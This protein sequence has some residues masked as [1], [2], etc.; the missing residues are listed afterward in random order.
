MHAGRLPVV[1]GV[2]GSRSS[3]SALRWGARQSQ[4]T[5]CPLRG[6]TAWHWPAAYGRVLSTIAFDLRADTT[7]LLSA[8][9]EQL[10]AEF[11]ELVLEQLVA[12]G[13]P[14]EVL[15]E[16]SRDASLLVVGDRGRS[17]VLDMVLGSVAAHCIRQAACPVAVMR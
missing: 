5:G 12:E 16:Q 13:H 10:L 6:V 8:V 17:A 3:L 15:V 4:L 14:A 11:P 2:D 9:A 1:V 7:E